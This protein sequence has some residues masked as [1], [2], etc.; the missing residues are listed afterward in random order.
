MTVLDMESGHHH[1]HH[2]HAATADAAAH[3]QPGILNDKKIWSVS[4][5][6]NR[7]VQHSVR[8]PHRRCLVL[9]AFGGGPI[10]TTTTN[11]FF[12]PKASQK[13]NKK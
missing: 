2:D 12:Q 7:K 4:R 8:W 10:F 1:H 3:V 5:R 11:F 6:G 9:L 13:F